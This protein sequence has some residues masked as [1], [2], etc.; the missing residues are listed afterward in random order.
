MSY[1]TLVGSRDTPR[2]SYEILEDMAR[3]LAIFKGWTGRS[4][5]ADGADS[6]LET[7]L[8][9]V[10]DK[11][12]V[13][14]PWTNFNGRVANSRLHLIDTPTFVNYR[15]A[16]LIAEETHPAW[17]RCSRGAKA[18][19]TRNVY[20]VLGRDLNTPSNLLICWAIPTKDGVKG[21]TNTAVQL[22]KKHGC[23]IIN[24][25]GKDY[26]AAINELKGMLE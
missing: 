3:Y 6:A 2:E 12:E 24:I 11:M 21:G 22:A 25:Y 14:L 18:L 17:D 15:E 8:L 26:T 1:F 19:H 9:K 7:A 16:M 23:Q 5:G 10:P 4:G 20:Q 13:Y